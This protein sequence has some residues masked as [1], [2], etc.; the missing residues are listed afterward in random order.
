MEFD[1]ALATIIGVLFHEYERRDFTKLMGMLRGLELLGLVRC[2]TDISD[3]ETWKATPELMR[4]AY[5][6]EKFLR[7]NRL[8]L[9]KAAKDEDA[10]ELEIARL[11]HDDDLLDAEP[12]SGTSGSRS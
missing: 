9:G 6:S 10:C 5:Q 8:A 12:E 3:N 1:D 11:K 4:L 2:C 7:E